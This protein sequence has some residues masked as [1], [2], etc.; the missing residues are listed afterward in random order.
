MSKLVSKLKKKYKVDSVVLL[1]MMNNYYIQDAYVTC[2]YG[3]DDE[4]EYG[5]NCYKDPV[6]I[7][8]QIVTLF[9]ASPLQ[10]SSL[11]KMQVMYLNFAQKEFPNDIMVN[12]KDPLSVLEIGAYTRYL[13][14]WTNKIDPQYEK[15]FIMVKKNNNH[16]QIKMYK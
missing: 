11:S 8:Q 14:G 5:I 16:K 15:L 4:I 12:Y 1:F 2:N 13:I 3:S 9:G 6:I 10:P 7:A